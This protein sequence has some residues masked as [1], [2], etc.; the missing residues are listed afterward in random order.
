[1]AATSSNDIAIAA[2]RLIVEEGLEYGAAK[3]RAARDLRAGG[4]Q[5]ELPGNDEIEDEV[6]AYLELFHADSQPA[7]L[8]ELRRIAA[9][10][11]E[12]LSAFRP[13]LTGAVWRGTATRLNSIRLDLFCDDSKSA[14]MALIDM[15]VDYE[16]GSSEGPRGRVLDVLNVFEMSPV[17]GGVVGV[18]MTVLDYDDLRGALRRDTRGRSERGD[19]AALRLLLAT[20]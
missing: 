20:A 16:V 11:M 5:G 15:R 4:R 17:L 18:S 10:W 8:A 12:R 9:R 6:R 13:H 7:E 14:E 19:L 3:R 2:A 1:M